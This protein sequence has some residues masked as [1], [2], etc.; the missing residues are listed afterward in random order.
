MKKTTEKKKSADKQRSST[1][2]GRDSAGRFVK[3]NDQGFQPGRSGNPHGRPK[4]RTLSEELR[5]RAEE[6]YAGRDDATY[7]RTVAEKLF[8]LAVA[9]EIAAIKEIFDRLEGRPRQ[10]IELSAD[11]Q[12]R[13]LIENAIDVL[14]RET[15][16]ERDTA[17]KDLLD[18]VPEAS[19]WIQ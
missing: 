16:V 14:M 15:G 18:L 3:G 5:A 4:K 7:A 9:G 2:K 1:G 13:K 17:V 19:Q 11:E 6:Q 8:D 12:K 10:A